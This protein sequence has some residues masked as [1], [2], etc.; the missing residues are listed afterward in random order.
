MGE[1]GSNDRTSGIGLYTS[2]AKLDNNNVELMYM[3]R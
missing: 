1:R 2:L 3:L